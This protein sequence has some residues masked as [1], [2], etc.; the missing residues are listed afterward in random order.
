MRL[1]ISGSPEAQKIFRALLRFIDPDFPAPPDAYHC[2]RCNGVTWTNSVLS[3]NGIKNLAR[4]VR[5]KIPGLRKVKIEHFA[6]S[7]T[8]YPSVGAATDKFVKC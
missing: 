8:C 1:N 7:S 2:T 4:Q 6:L 3:P 5:H